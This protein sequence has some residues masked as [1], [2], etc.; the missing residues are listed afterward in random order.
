MAI[1][2]KWLTE[3]PFNSR[4]DLIQT[5]A[6]TPSAVATRAMTEQE[7][8]RVMEALNTPERIHTLPIFIAVMDTGVRLSSLP[9]HLRWQDVYFDEEL[10]MV[11]AYKRKNK[12]QW[13]TRPTLQPNQQT[14]QSKTKRPTQNK[15]RN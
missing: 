5:A 6:E 4:P 15:L 12:Q 14:D 13:P 10:I 1:R 7:A 8:E 11:T 3:N 2:K 9:D